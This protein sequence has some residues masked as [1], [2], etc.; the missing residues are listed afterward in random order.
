[1]SAADA[2][3][4]RTGADEHV[5]DA[6]RG[7]LKRLDKGGNLQRARAVALWKQIAGEEVAGHARGYALRGTELVVFVDSPVWATE[8]AALS[9][10]YRTQLNTEAGQELVGSIRFTVS[11]K[12]AEDRAWDEAREREEEERRPD[13]V[14]PVAAT[15]QELAQIDAMAAS[16]HDEALREAAIGAAVRALEWRKGLK[17]SK[18]PQTGAGGS[19]GPESGA[20]H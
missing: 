3:R 15:T 18:T 17:A 20:A 1:M 2:R 14:V 6:V 11:K 16:I 13:R 8:L 7:F 10:R 5:S 9:E 4:R 19:Q 12:V